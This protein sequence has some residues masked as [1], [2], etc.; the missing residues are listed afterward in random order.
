MIA[1]CGFSLEETGADTSSQNGMAERPNNTFGE[2]MR[3]MLK[4]A[5]LGPEFWS[6]ALIYAAYL[7]NRMYH[8][9]IR[10]TPYKMMTGEKPNLSNIKIFGCKMCAK[11]NQQKEK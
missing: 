5:E 3:T 9:A 7:K 10:K 11:K 6:F 8:I 2:M 1:E 4:S